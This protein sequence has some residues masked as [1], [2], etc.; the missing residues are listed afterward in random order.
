MLRRLVLAALFSLGAFSASA[1]IIPSGSNFTPGHTIRCQNTGCTVAVDA[2]GAAGSQLN[3]QG[4]L[5]E[6]GITNTGTPFCINDALTNAPGGYHQFCLGA[7]VN[8]QGLISYNAY[9]GAT[10]DPLYLNLN[11]VQ[12]QLPFNVSAITQ[13]PCTNSISSFGGGPGVPDNTA[14]FNAAVAVNAT[15]SCVSFPPGSYTF[16]SPLVVNM[17]NTVAGGFSMSGAGPGV[18]VLTWPNAGGGL[19]VNLNSHKQSVFVSGLELTTGQVGGGTAITVNQLALSSSASLDPTTVFNRVA[20]HGADGYSATDYWNTGIKTSRVSNVN[21]ISDY[22]AGDSGFNATGIDLEGS[23][24]QPAAQFSIMASNF[25]CLNQGLLYGS[26]VQGVAVSGGSNFVCGNY[27]IIVPAGGTSL[28]QLT[29]VGNEFNVSKYDILQRT[30]VPGTIITNNIFIAGNNAA[31]N[32]IGIGIG[33]GS[34]AINEQFTIAHNNFQASQQA[35]DVGIDV[36]GSSIGIIQG[37]QC[38]FN[39]LC[40]KLE[41]NTGQ[42]RITDDNIY[43]ANTTNLSNLNASNQID[44]TYAI[45]AGGFYPTAMT[46]AGSSTAGTWTYTIQTASIHQT[47][48]WITVNF[49]LSASSIGTAAGNLLIKGLPVANGS[50]EYG[51]CMLSNISGINTPGSPNTQIVASIAPSATQIVFSQGV[52]SV[53]AEVAVP[54]SQITAAN[55]SVYGSCQYHT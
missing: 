49:N 5:T 11:G 33:D 41:A 1:Q 50:G 55:F 44:G 20:I 25:E 22:I 23:S 17:P 26:Y 30:S 21:F 8:G 6:L 43:G 48:A 36:Y 4:Y 34:N 27:G 24:A 3:G 19:T 53:G 47:G 42:I 51:H 46:A 14:A 2:G 39:T 15:N 40:F 7:N 13:S 45:G 9:G 37:N 31:T 12:Y 28:D 32:A 10:P 16:L 38:T 52:S 29:V 18:A 35:G 54:I